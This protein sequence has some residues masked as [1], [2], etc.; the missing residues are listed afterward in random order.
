MKITPN[1]TD[2]V[3][4]TEL[5]ERLARRRINLAKTQQ[6]LAEE[7]G[8]SRRTIQYAEAGGSVQSESLIRLLRALGLLGTLDALLPEQSVSPMDMLKLK[9]KERKRVRVTQG[10]QAATDEWKW[11]DEQ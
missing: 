8:L 11:G 10:A 5:G 3:V 6:Q 2:Q 4:L 9:K 1:L 7:S